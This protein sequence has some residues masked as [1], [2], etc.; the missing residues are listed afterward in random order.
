MSKKLFYIYY[1]DDIGPGDKIVVYNYTTFFEDQIIA[2]L[3]DISQNYNIDMNNMLLRYFPHIINGIT[4]TYKGTQRIG[5]EMWLLGEDYRGDDIRIDLH[6]VENCSYTIQPR[7][8]RS[9]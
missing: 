8:E 4:F 3:D 5:G 2:V 1:D 6:N 7:E 9:P